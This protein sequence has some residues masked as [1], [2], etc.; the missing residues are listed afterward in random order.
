MTRQK[1]KS[2]K[3]KGEYFPRYSRRPCVLPLS[4]PLGRLVQDALDVKESAWARVGQQ[5]TSFHGSQRDG[6]IS[7]PDHG[8]RTE[9]T[10]NGGHVRHGYSDCHAFSDVDRHS[11]VHADGHADS[12]LFAF[13]LRYVDG[14]SDAQSHLQVGGDTRSPHGDGNGH[15]AWNPYSHRY[16]NTHTDARAAHGSGEQP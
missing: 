14:H 11:Y 16:A 15:A 4:V 12:D 8:G 10:A 13:S 3:A 5:S 9:P 7:W 6:I 2:E 1:L